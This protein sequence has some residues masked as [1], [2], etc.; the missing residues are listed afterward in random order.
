M[1][2][3]WQGYVAAGVG[4]GKDVIAD[5]SYR[6][7]ATVQAANGVHAD[8]H[9]FELTPRGTALITA[10]YPVIWDASSVHGS[11]HEV[12][13]DSIVQ[14]I[15]IATGLLLF[16]WDSLDHVP[17]TETYSDLPHRRTSPFDYFHVNSIEPDSDGNL[18]LSARNTWAAYKVSPLNGAVIWRLGG[19]R[20]SFKLARGV[21]WAFQ[22]DVRVRAT[23][24]LFVT[25]FDDSAGPPTVHPQSRGVKLILDLKHMTARQVAE[26]VHTPSL[27]A[28]FEGNFQQLPNGDDFLGW[29]Q[30]PISPSTTPRER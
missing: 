4:I 18:I 2:T 29:G 15:D 12:V 23:N 14:E 7:V 16:Q 3:W 30:Q 11:R 25:L 28:K 8:L 10:A 19:K 21:H 27:S 1:L 22:H 20:S 6:Q 5:S 17:V 9:E 26:H 13:F 24:D